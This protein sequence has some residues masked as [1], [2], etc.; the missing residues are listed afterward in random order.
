MVVMLS[1]WCVLRVSY[2]AV[3]LHFVNQLET[4]SFAYPIT[5][6]CSSII[7]V[8]YLWKGNWMYA[9]QKHKLA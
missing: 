2:I 6:T 9:F 5:W 8:I 7:F 4:V 1:C 3:A